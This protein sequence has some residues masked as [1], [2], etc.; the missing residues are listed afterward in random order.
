MGKVLLFCFLIFAALN[1]EHLSPASYN[2][3]AVLWVF[4]LGW[5]MFGNSKKEKP[6][7]KRR[8][9]LDEDDD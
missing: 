5:V 2:F 7:K 6:K 3:V 8:F 9:Y 1:C 4:F